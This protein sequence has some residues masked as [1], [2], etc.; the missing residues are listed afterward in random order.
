MFERFVNGFQVL[1]AIATVVTVV[2]LLTVSPTV[3]EPAET[4]VASG[5]DLFASNCAGCH[6]AAGE[7]GV[8]PALAGGLT[9]FD[10]IEEVVSFVS[11]GVPGSMPGFETRLSPEEIEAVVDYVWVDLAGR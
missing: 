9:R 2:L 4:A 10:S 3:A 5:A 6:G 7:G 8:G 1:V 11:T